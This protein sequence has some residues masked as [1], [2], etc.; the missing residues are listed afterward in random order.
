MTDQSIV[1]YHVR[2]TFEIDGIVD[3]ADVIGAIFG[4][5]EGI[6]GPEMNLNELQKNYKV[7]RIEI[8]SNSKNGKTSGKVT[9]PMS[10]DIS[11]TS[12]VAGAVESIE[13]VGPCQSHFKL[14]S[15]DDVRSVRRQQIVDRAKEIMRDWSSKTSSEGEN[16]VKEVSESAK[17]SKIIEYG[18]DKLPAG[19]E[20]DRSKEIIIVEG[21]ADVLLHLRAGI[22][23][24]IAVE[25]T[26]IPDAII[27]LVKSKD[28]V[29]AFLDGDR[30][31]D[32]ILRELQQVTKLDR[33]ARAPDGK[34]VEDLT[35][36][37]ILDILDLEKSSDDFGVNES[38]NESTEKIEP[39]VKLP[40]DITKKTADIFNDING[41]LEGIILDENLNENLRV[42]VSGLVK[43]IESSTN[44]KYIVFDG[45]I[46]QRLVDISDK[47][48]IKYIIG[49]K[50]GSDVKN[51]P[52]ELKLVTFHELALK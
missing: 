6:F 3:K 47:A 48:G 17:R 34:E 11:T 50:T 52:E 30:G 27:D 43:G 20:V 44:S 40:E 24:V 1:K 15:L 49:N 22:E 33:V 46:T 36:V 13:K 29:T 35:P 51:T 9:I 25:G 18:R 16:I 10:T 5:T 32:L 45:I 2:L 21:R 39:S 7:G 26:N 12:L 4:Q 23:N 14:E 28:K 8:N 31:G 38:T 37:E 41:S 42:P 19:P